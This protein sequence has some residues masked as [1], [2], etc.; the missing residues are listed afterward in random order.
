MRWMFWKK[1]PEPETYEL[2]MR[3]LR[4]GFMQALRAGARMPTLG[5][6]LQLDPR[7]QSAMAS[8][9][10]AVRAEL[11][12]AIARAM[13][14]ADGFGEVMSHVDGGTLAEAIL[15]EDALISAARSFLHASEAG[16]GVH[17]QPDHV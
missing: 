14:G 4:A 6:F 8:A 17:W 2:D 5:E 16:N 13:S 7:I 12:C 1:D 10:T 11:A 3:S 9:G 15:C